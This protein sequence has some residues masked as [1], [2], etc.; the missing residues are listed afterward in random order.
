MVIA[1]SPTGS[2][3]PL[4]AVLDGWQA[5]IGI[6]IGEP[7]VDGFPVMDLDSG[8]APDGTYADPFVRDMIDAQEAERRRLARELHDTVGQALM[9]VR[10]D[11][12]LLRREP[13]RLIGRRRLNA[14]LAIVDEAMASVRDFALELRP[15]VLDDLGL[16]AATRWYVRRQSRIGGFR[17]AVVSNAAASGFGAETETACFRVLQEALT[18]VVRHSHATR[19]RVELA[20]SDDALVLTVADNGIGFDAGPRRPGPGSGLGLMGMRER[21]RH[22]GGSLEVISELGRGARIVAR[23][24]RSVDTGSVGA[25]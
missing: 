1:A 8:Q 18:N 19:V 14:S 25:A 21:T 23:F 16:I 11:L 2:G 9:A 15:P 6:A 4:G 22:L 7:A 3:E 24:S 12:E 13:R 5:V 17:V 20:G 10:F